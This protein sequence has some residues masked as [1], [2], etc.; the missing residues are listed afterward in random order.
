MKR[1]WMPI[2]IGDYLAE[3]GHLT[4]AE[5]GAY[6][7]L[8]M[9]YWTHSG[10]PA[11]EGAIRRISKMTSRQWSLSRDVLKALFGE[12]WRHLA[13]D[14]EIRKA[15]EI[16]EANSANAR[17]SHANRKK[18]AAESQANSRTQQH[19]HTNSLPSGESSPP[20]PEVGNQIGNPKSS[21]A[22]TL[23]PN[24]TPNAADENVA[25]GYGMSQ[26]DIASEVKKFRAYHAEKGSASHDWSASWLMWCSRWDGK[27]TPIKPSIGGEAGAVQK[28]HVKADTPEWEAWQ[29]YL[30]KTTGKGTP[31]DK[32]FGWYFD[33]IWPP[34]YP[35]R[36][37]DGA[38]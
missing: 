24:W 31:T 34:G 18:F 6:N 5:H 2:N 12:G 4:V 30:K 9:Y 10:L 7:L 11:E 20:S 28:V 32:N 38:S 33:S 15:I 35:L 3:T 1:F 21:S 22:S 29:A 26:I 14:H 17:K 23:A 13:L 37:E 19:L 27:P 36:Q 25:S 16:S 8:R